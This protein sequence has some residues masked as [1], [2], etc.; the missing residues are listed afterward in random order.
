MEI[1]T[2]DRGEQL[3]FEAALG[4][5]A[6]FTLAECSALNKPLVISSARKISLVQYCRNLPSLEIFTS[7][8][9]NV[10]FLVASE[11]LSTLKIICSTLENI[12]MLSRCQSLENLEIICTFVED[13]N[14]LMDLPRL[15]RG[16]LLGNPWTEESY[17]QLRP[18]LLTTPTAEWK[19]P[20]V[21]EFSN[22]EDW[23]L[24][25]QLW[26]YGLKVCFANFDGNRSVLVKP[27][28]SNKT[29][30]NCDFISEDRVIVEEELEKP[31]LTTDLLFDNLLLDR[32]PTQIERSF[33]FQSHRILGDSND[34]RM[35]VETSSLPERM[36][37]FLLRF[38]S[39]FP[40]LTFYKEDAA[41]LDR[42]EEE[43]KVKLPDWL[44]SMRQTLAFVEPDFQQYEILVQFG[45]F[46]PL[47]PESLGYS[48]FEG[49]WY[50]LSLIGYYSDENRRM[51]SSTDEKICLLGAGTERKSGV[52]FAINTFDETDQQVYKY[53]IENLELY[54]NEGYPLSSCIGIAFNS[55]AGMFGHIV[56]IKLKNGA[57]VSA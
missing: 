32:D 13:L 38:I 55:Y 9:K 43:L 27:G 4:H 36:K 24:T 1:N 28:I 53:N 51:L 42:K 37:L 17:H 18:K 54:M 14:P 48:S 44:R 47:K 56:A 10:D 30:L 34:A 8:I 29:N 12:Q 15:R 39:R 5:S 33:D 20:P 52:T 3:A 16:V 19:K 35:W 45:Q 26:E 21:I 23:Q 57:V 31:N 7:E 6:P 25:R 22:T 41:L 2:S 50:S 40:T 49:H 46:E 11:N